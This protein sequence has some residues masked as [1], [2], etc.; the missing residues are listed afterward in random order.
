MHLSISEVLLN[1]AVVGMK[2]FDDENKNK[3]K[4]GFVWDN[5]DIVGK[6]VRVQVSDTKSLSLK[7]ISFIGLIEFIIKNLFSLSIKLN[8]E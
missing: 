7:S 3:I 5:V 2:E 6:A 8:I 1:G 4:G